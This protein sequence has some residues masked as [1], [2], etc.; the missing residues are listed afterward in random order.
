MPEVILKLNKLSDA[1]VLKLLKKYNIGLTVAEA[2]KIETEILKRPMTLTEAT[3]WSIQGS[4]HCSYKSSRHYLKQLPT[5]G[6]NVIQGP[7]EDAGIVEIARYQ[8]ERWGIVFAHESHNHP[9]Q[10]VPYEGAATGVGGIVRDVVCMGAKV[11]ACADPLRFGEI[12]SNK[13]KWIAQ[14]VVA[15]IGGYG[16]P[17][18]IPN[19][20]GDVYWNSS[21]NENCLVNVVALGLVKESEVIHSKA[22]VGAADGRHDLIL[23]GKPTDNS[24]FGGASFASFELDEAEK[25]KNKGAVQ[26]PNAFLERHLL[27]STYAL[28]A[29]LKEKKLLDKVGFKDMGGGGILC[30]SVEM[31]DAAGFG[32]MVDLDKIHVAMANLP[33]QVILAAETQERFMWVAQADVTPLILKHYNVTWALPKVSKGA[34]ASVIGRI[35]T[36]GQYIVK[37]K[38]LEKVVDAR[39]C[40]ITRGLKYDRPVKEPKQQNL[41]PQIPEPKDYNEVLSKILAHENIA[42]RDCVYERYDKTVQGY[43]VIEPG[44]A[45]AGV[46]KPLIDED[47]PEELKRI[48]IALAVDANPLYG[49]IS[50]YWGAVNA[51]AEAT[52]NVAAVGAVPWSLTD[53]LCYGNPEKPEQMWQFAEGVRGIADA[54]KN[55]YLKG[56]EAAPLPVI[57]GNVSLY[58]ESKKGPV[59]PSPIIAC[60]G[61]MSDYAKAVTLEFKEPDSAIMLIGSRKNEL[62]GSVYYQL[63]N[64]L[65]AN[66][67]QPEFAEVRNQ[68][69]AVTDLIDQRLLLACHDISDGG[70]AVT[71]SEMCFG[72]NGQNRIGAE[73]D[74]RYVP[75]SGLNLSAKLFS[76][77]GGFVVETKMLAEVKKICGKYGVEII[78]LG[79]TNKNKELRIKN[80]EKE[81][82][83]LSVEDMADKWLNGLRDKMNG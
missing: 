33:P 36:D 57:S 1:E 39:A 22:P 41:E 25:E 9:S 71:L 26:E 81:I 18:G 6:P 59:D 48:G 31:A 76:E 73:A 62:G 78:E 44:R 52:R 24:G 53:C 60:L 30:G 17:L 56:Y 2:R 66:V 38:G 51:V 12:S 5:S 37:Y 20:A 46:M 21:F 14:G 55:I 15:G 80:E 13:S 45:D 27:E 19:I 63:F 79:Q 34:R 68:L 58:N 75:A 8:G 47:L 54:C 77:T 40:D 64:E 50:S 72:G 74:L 69:Y 82:I 42:S 28:F 11:I 32:A 3:A 23:V 61:R 29:L 35:T 7:E 49:R 43:T 4:E 70:L 65:G 67:P 10:L 83:R 16:N